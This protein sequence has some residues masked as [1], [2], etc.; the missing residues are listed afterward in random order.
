MSESRSS[1]APMCRASSLR[2][3]SNRL[4]PSSLWSYSSGGGCDAMRV[5][6]LV[7]GVCGLR[8][9]WA[10][11][12]RPQES[13][14]AVSIAPRSHGLRRCPVSGVRGGDVDAIAV[15]G[16]RIERLPGLCPRPSDANLDRGRTCPPLARR[17]WREPATRSLREVVL[18]TCSLS[19]PAASEG[20]SQWRRASLKWSARARRE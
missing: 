13:G 9:R 1:P 3:H 7:R 5:P 10:R 18:T 8:S 14:P 12:L 11:S 2:G 6:F 17:R 4:S 20:R 15:D 19:P 16:G